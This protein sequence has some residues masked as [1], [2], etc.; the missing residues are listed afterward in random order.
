MSKPKVFVTRAIPEKGFAIVRDFC[1]VDLWPNELPPGREPI[2]TEIRDRRALPKIE[3]FLAA[4]DDAIKQIAA[5]P[6]AAQLLSNEAVALIKVGDVET[7]TG[8]R[9]SALAKYRDALKI[10]EQLSA[11]APSDVYLR[12]DLDE[13]SMKVRTVGE[14]SR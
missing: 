7:A 1:D 11:A 2:R 5:D 10:R 13:A 12:R 9:A 6:A 8:R 14:F 4:L 3:A